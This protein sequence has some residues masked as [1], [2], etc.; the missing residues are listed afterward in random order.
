M[1]LSRSIFRIESKLPEK[2]AFGT[3][4]SVYEDKNGTYIVTC[5]HV[6]KAVGGQENAKVKEMD[7]SEAVADWDNDAADMVILKTAKSLKS[8]PLPLCHQAKEKD[9]IRIVGYEKENKKFT[10]R[11]FVGRLSSPTEKDTGGAN[12]VVEGWD[13]KL[14]DQMGLVGGYSGSPVLLTDSD[15]VIGMITSAFAEYQVAELIGI[16]FLIYL[17]KKLQGPIQIE[18]IG[19]KKIDSRESLLNTLAVAESLNH[20]GLDFQEICSKIGLDDAVVI[21]SINT[22]KA[23]GLICE[24]ERLGKSVLYMLTHEGRTALARKS[25]S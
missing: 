20:R 6:L 17:L 10:K 18:Q 24:Y 16:D 12:K 2:S 7:I 14:N 9:E 3:G 25:S 22:L 15:C 21:E 19:K 23:N 13:C 5:M 8:R 1:D 11:S 4:F